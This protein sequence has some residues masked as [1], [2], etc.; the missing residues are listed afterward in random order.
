LRVESL[1]HLLGIVTGGDVETAARDRGRFIA[2][3]ET[4]ATWASDQ[5]RLLE[6]ADVTD[7]ERAE[8]AEIILGCGGTIENLPIA[9]SGSRWLTIG[10]L[11][12]LI[13]SKLQIAVHVGTITYE[14]DDDVGEQ[15]FYSEFK[16][17]QDIIIIAKS[18]ETFMYRVRFGRDDGRPSFLL[19]VF[20]ELLQTNWGGFEEEDDDYY[21]IGIAGAQ[22]FRPVTI[23]S[24]ADSKS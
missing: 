21:V 23:Y 12:P 20:E 3:P 10:E 8:G 4:F 14:T 6:Q 17:A 22:I 16:L 11:R 7:E 2:P 24:R 9:Y 5:G 13:A 18:A 1:P 19:A 15:Y